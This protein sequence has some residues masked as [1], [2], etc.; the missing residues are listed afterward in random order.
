MFIILNP[1]VLVLFALVNKLRKPVSVGDVCPCKTISVSNARSSNSGSVINLHSTKSISASNICS[2]KP[3]CRK[4]VCLRNSVSAINIH[5]TKFV[6]VSDICLG[7]HV[8]RKNVPSSKPICRSNVCQSKL[9]NVNKLPCK[10]VLSD[11][12]YYVNS[13]ILSQQLFFYISPFHFNIFSVL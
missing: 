12:T 6:K 1:L 7:K 9:T 8:C 13:S 2:G 5:P 10:P 11:H 4:N 3:V